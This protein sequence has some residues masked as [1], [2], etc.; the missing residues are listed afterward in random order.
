MPLR[1]TLIH[2]LAAGTAT[3][4]LVLSWVPD[5]RMGRLPFMPGWLGDWLDSGGGV[6]TMRTGLAMAVAAAL[7]HL[8]GASRDG[9]RSV[10]LAAALLLAAEGGQ[11]FLDSRQASL[12][13][14]GWGLAG[15]VLGVACARGL[16][17][18]GR[19]PGEA[20]SNG[21]DPQGTPGA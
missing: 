5:S 2:C 12:G 4:V 1:Q 18:Q 11:L 15:C 17:G 9:R 16:A 6:N 21:S 14:V 7:I 10:A 20:P 3:L 8:A 19:H 13:D